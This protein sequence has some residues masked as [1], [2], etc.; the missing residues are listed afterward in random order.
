MAEDTAEGLKDAIRVDTAELRGHVDEVVRSSVEETLNA[1]LQAE[2]DQICE[3][4]R[5]ER[6]PERVDTR[7]GSYERKLETKAGVVTLK[8][9]KLRRLPF[10]TAIIERYRRREVVGR[11]SV[12]GDVPGGSERAAGGR[13]HRSAVGHPGELGD[14][15]AA[16]PEDLSP[17]RT[18]RAK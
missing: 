18:R 16:E 4:G 17:H 6:S 8:V 12:G 10:E 11:G 1:L 7:A 5:Y 3:R 2:A 15:V 13:H 14:G 9:P